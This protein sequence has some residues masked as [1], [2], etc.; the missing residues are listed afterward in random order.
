MDKILLALYADYLLSSFGQTTAT[1]L[2]DVL[3][4]TISHDKI[5]RFLANTECNSR[6][7]WRLVKPTVRAITQQEGGVILDDTIAENAWTDENDLIT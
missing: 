2:S 7:L 4:H 6:E 5:T 1:G 3:D